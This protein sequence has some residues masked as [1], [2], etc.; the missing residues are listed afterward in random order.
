MR[1]QL[2]A[3]I[4]VPVRSHWGEKALGRRKNLNVVVRTAE[5]CTDSKKWADES[6]AAF[7]VKDLGSKAVLKNCQTSPY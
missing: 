5:D 1:K 6:L 2:R 7:V 4:A 3:Y